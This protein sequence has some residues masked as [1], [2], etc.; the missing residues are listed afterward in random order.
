MSDRANGDAGRAERLAAVREQSFTCTRRRWERRRQ[1]VFGEGNQDAR[2]T[3]VGEGPGDVEDRTGRPFQGP[4]GQLLDR[5][6]TRAGID[7]ADLWVTNTVKSRAADPAGRRL[8]TVL[9]DGRESSVPGSGS[10]PS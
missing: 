10:T 8:K 5:A 3:I 4:A 2:M 7:R 9:P 1:V 6:L